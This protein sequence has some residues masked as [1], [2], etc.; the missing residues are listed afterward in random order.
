MQLQELNS[1]FENSELLLCVACLNPDNLFSAFN[2]E[3]LIRLAQFYPS[4]FSTVQVSSLD[5]QLETYI[6]YMRSSEEFSALKGIGQLTEKMVEMKKNVSYPLVYSL[7]TLALILP[8]ATATVERAFSAMNIIKNRL[9]RTDPGTYSHCIKKETELYAIV[10]DESIKPNRTQ[11]Q[12][13]W[14]KPPP[15]LGE[16]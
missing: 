16:A 2:K 5:N 7:V 10:P 1:R 4:D 12:V 6:H 3:K 15:N 14:T 11:V 13:K 8:V 9:R